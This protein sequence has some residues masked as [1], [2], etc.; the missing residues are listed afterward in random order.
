M[1]HRVKR[2]R[3]NVAAHQGANAMALI[4]VALYTASNQVPSS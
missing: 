2:R 1:A 3:E 4:D